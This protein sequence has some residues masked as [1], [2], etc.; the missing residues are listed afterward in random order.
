MSSFR[1][2]HY[3]RCLLEEIGTDTPYTLDDIERLRG[4][5]TDEEMYTVGRLLERCL[6]R[7]HR[8]EHV[9][10]SLAR[11]TIRRTSVKAESDEDRLKAI[12]GE[13]YGGTTLG[14]EGGEFVLYR[15][16]E[17]P[18]SVTI[19]GKGRTIAQALD[20][21]AQRGEEKDR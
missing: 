21:R 11:D 15:W 20:N 12:L 14:Y 19:L 16:S 1:S 5:L 4:K 2:R 17:A 3:L 18:T 6:L 9:P 8:L 13:T 10:S 7:S